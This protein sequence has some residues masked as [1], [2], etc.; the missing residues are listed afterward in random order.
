MYRGVGV[1]R[2]DSRIYTLSVPCRRRRKI[3]IFVRDA[4]WYDINESTADMNDG[5]NMN[6]H[7]I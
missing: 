1:G 5:K 6:A 2:R 7:C 4:R 3:H